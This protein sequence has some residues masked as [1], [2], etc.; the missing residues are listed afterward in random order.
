MGG[1][2]AAKMSLNDPQVIADGV[3][4]LVNMAPGTRPLRL[5]L[6]AVADGADQEF[7]D[8]R[9]SL[10]AKLLANYFTA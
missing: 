4:A 2:L 9:A 6:D 3:L 7:V 5:P 8:A 1:V 10:K